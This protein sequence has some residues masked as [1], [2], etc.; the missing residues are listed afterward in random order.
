MGRENDA[1]GALLQLVAAEWR[2]QIETCV[3]SGLPIR[4]LNAHEHV[5][6]LPGLMPIVR[7][8]AGEYGIAFI[9]RSA[10]DWFYAG[11]ARHLVR[12]GLMQ[13]LTTINARHAQV[14]AM[15]RMLGLSVSGRLDLPYLRVA[16][17]RLRPGEVAELMC[18]PGYVE[19]SLPTDSPLR[20]YHDWE[21]ELRLLTGEGLRQLLHREDLSLIRFSDLAD[22]GLHPFQP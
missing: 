22:R 15:P 12:N 4:F 19:P 9:R 13:I 5:H 8:L 2:A 21:A 3:S 10:P 1:R 6:M 11:S 7:A 18:H 20:A 16:L 14:G 17:S